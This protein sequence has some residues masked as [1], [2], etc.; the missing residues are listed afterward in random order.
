MLKRKG[1]SLIEI[2]TVI[3]IIIVVVAIIALR[4]NRAIQKS[5]NAKVLA[6]LEAIRSAITSLYTDTGKFPNGCPPFSTQNPEVFF[7]EDTAGIISRPPVGQVQGMC[8][9]TQGAVDN[10]DGPYIEDGRVI[11]FWGNT[12]CLKFSEDVFNK[13]FIYIFIG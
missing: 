13:F 9:W 1:F 12:Y 6:D 11:D 3:T 4:A 7:D 8:W 10:W 5:A 2:V